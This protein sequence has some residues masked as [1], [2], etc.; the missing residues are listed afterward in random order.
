M[1]LDL[2]LLLV[3]PL[4]GYARLEMRVLVWVGVLQYW[5]EGCRVVI[6]GV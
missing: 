3:G 5:Q 1:V 6:L 4:L 2:S